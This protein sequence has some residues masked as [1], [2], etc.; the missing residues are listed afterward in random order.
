MSNRNIFSNS[1]EFAVALELRYGFLIG[2]K[3]KV[4][5]S[6]NNGNGAFF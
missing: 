1:N 2:L 3:K 6:Q 4:E 5:P